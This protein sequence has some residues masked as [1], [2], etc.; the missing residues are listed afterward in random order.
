MSDI[1]QVT[2]NRLSADMD[3]F[4]QLLTTQMQNQDPL[5][6]TDPTDFVA[7]LAQ[8]STVE[9]SVQTNDR[10]G[11][12]FGQLQADSLKIDSALIDKAAEVETRQIALQ[13]GAADIQYTLPR[14]AAEA[15][16]RIRDANGEIVAEVDGATDAGDHQM[17]WDGTGAGGQTLPSGLYSVEIL[18]TD[19][20]GDPI[21]ASTRAHGVIAQVQQ[22]DGESRFTLDNGITVTESAIT[23]V[24]RL[25]DPPAAP[26]GGG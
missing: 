26:A 11:E 15:Q 9:Q 16:V 24:S 23:R 20:A 8:F 12:I 2:G 13:D 3:T 19:A 22:G 21:P 18:A 17:R 1:Q 10:L 5:K 14:Q 25:P 6:P 4:L 7:Q